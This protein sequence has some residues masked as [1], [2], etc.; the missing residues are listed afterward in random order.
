M[1]HDD[2]AVTFGIREYATNGTT[3]RHNFQPIEY[4]ETL[5]GTTDSF[6]SI[7]LHSSEI[8]KY[9]QAQATLTGKPG[10]TGYKKEV[11]CDVLTIDIDVEGDLDRAKFIAKGMLSRLGN[12]FGVDCLQVR[13]V[14]SGNKGFHIDIPSQLFGGFIPSAQLPRLHSKIVQLLASGFEDA[15]DLGIYYT[16]GLIRVENTRHSTSGL[17]AIPLT[18]KEVNSLKIEEIKAMAEDTRDLAAVDPTALSFSQRLVDLKD[19]CL[20]ELNSAPISA[21]TTSSF[22]YTSCD[23]TKFSTMCRHCHIMKEIK[24]KA[25]AKE[26]IGH[27]DR[28]ILGTVATAFGEDGVKIVHDMLAGQDNYD[29]Q[30]TEYYMQTM[31]QNAYKPTLC[32]TICGR[33]KLCE[34]MK[35]INKRS[36]IAFAYTY[37]GTVD[38]EVK[39]FVETYVIEKI[40]RHFSNYIFATNDESYYKY[41]GGVYN[42]LKD[43]DLKSALEDFLPF[44]LPKPL[45]TNTR[46]NG[47]VER[48]KT[49]RGIRY[50]G[51]FNAEVYRINLRNGLYN[52]KS[53]ILEPHTP[54]YKSNIQLPFAFDRNATSQVFDKFL[55][56]IFDNQSDVVEYILKYWCYLLLP[57]YNF[58]KVL[59]WIGSGRNGKG[60]LSRI[61][62]NM[63]GP[64][65][66]SYQDLHE[67]AK[68]RFSAKNLK[69]K[70]VNFSSELK[71]D[72]VELGM[73]KK[74][75][76]GDLISADVKFKDE[77]VFSNI[78][79][80]IIMANELPRFSDVGNSITQRFEFIRFPKEYNG[81]DV[82]TMLDE[83][84]QNEL[85][86]IFNKVIG[87]FADIVQT[88]GSIFFDAP[89]SIVANKAA[90]MSDL[91]N[92]VEF[93]ESEC[94]RKADA[95]RFLSD[96]Y[97]RYA[98]WTKESGYKAYGK[99]HF[100]NILESNLKLKVYNCSRHQNSVCVDGIQ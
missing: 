62:Q 1:N 64:N 72:D 79:R 15:V 50:E 54:A 78:A 82:D 30:R 74:L 35:A 22:S 70:L 98:A 8:E 60:T 69:D 39:N 93:V 23:P 13:I 29:K 88:D 32:D 4:V 47:L 56:D 86:G 42:A 38:E 52:L 92:V 49:M 68:G 20:R 95:H 18:L 27:P 100:R 61:I 59:V 76:G 31:A 96:I 99:K 14:F 24:R 10:L 28:I 58:Q 90:A 46:L 80:L 75:S 3:N 84:L 21:V 41:D 34:P 66:I 16:V 73:I 5:N 17:F 97:L 77:V 83:K 44:Y 37:D 11:S 43:A 63:L 87:K 53:G 55:L 33:D 51:K 6:Q 71:T 57:T 12:D 7:Y 89:D 2:N 26:V 81:S 48:L 19:Q 85:S 67:L 25:Q 9:F 91:S 65:N 45:I 36:P 94:I 40:V